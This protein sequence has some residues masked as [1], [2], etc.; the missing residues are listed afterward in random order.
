MKSNTINEKQVWS[1]KSIFNEIN[2][3]AD[4]AKFAGTGARENVQ[5][6]EGNL[7][8]FNGPR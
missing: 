2:T 3:A 4:I 7:N 6:A 1:E 5:N 8:V